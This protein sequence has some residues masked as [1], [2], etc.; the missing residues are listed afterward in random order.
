MDHIGMDHIGNG[1]NRTLSN[2]IL[3]MSTNPTKGE[4]LVVCI[5]MLSKLIRVE[6]SI[7]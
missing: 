5:T 4:P 6:H 2:P 1:L 7:I 3:M